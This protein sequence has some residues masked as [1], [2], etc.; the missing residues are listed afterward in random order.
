MLRK[1]PVPGWLLS[2]DLTRGIG[3]SQ[4]Y[5]GQVVTVVTNSAN[6]IGK[7][8]K[9]ISTKKR[10]FNAAILSVAFG[11]LAVAEY[12]S[13]QTAGFGGIPDTQRPNFPGWPKAEI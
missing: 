8:M 1:P 7:L 4:G 2:G 13:R 5:G 3:W 12:T 9:H 6:P 10:T 11:S